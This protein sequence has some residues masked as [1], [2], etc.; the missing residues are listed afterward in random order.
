M[1]A[2]PFDLQALLQ[3]VNDAAPCGADLVHD[4]AFQALL[5]AARGK[6]DQQ[7]GKTV[8]EAVEPNWAELCRMAVALLARSK[9]LRV[10]MHLLR[11]CTRLHGLG[12]LACGLQL[13]DGLLE[14]W[15]DTLHPRLD[16][17]DGGDPTMRLNALRP[18][19]DGTAL[20]LDARLVTLDGA[21]VGLTGRDLELIAGRE[22]PKKGEPVPSAEGLLQALHDAQARD[23]G[24]LERLAGARESV[25]RIEACLQRHVGQAGPDLQAL[26]R[27]TTLLAET[28]ARARAATPAPTA[29]AAAPLVP[30]LPG[31]APGALRSREDVMREL[32][33][34]CEWI[35]QNEP[36]HPAPLLIQRARRL[37]AKSFMDIVKD[38]LPE[39]VAQVQKLA[40]VA[41]KP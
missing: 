8:R 26:R 39:G 10:A 19:A 37:M 32:Q 30:G 31:A 1:P 41:D 4:E 20:L 6:P 36:G 33:R 3:P 17:E 23:P 11:A 21:R 14:R 25:L 13:I 7:F 34:A 5:D 18:L 9:D 27:F 22:A 15:W 16:A 29:P 40:G 28:T 2:P 24:L 35:E 12:G 38:L